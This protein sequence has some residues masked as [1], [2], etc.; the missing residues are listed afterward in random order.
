MSK[1]TPLNNETRNHIRSAVLKHRFEKEAKRLDKVR[2]GTADEFYNQMLTPSQRRIINTAPEGWFREKTGVFFYVMGESHY[3][4]FP[5][6]KPRR[7]P[8][9]FERYSNNAVR[10]SDSEGVGLTVKTYYADKKKMD[11]D[12]DAASAAVG[13]TLRAFRYVEDLVEAWPEVKKFIPKD[14]VKAATTALAIPPKQLNE[15]LGLS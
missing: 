14:A 7:V 9:N 6:D 15:M 11:D 10:A 2:D 3:C 4:A 13:E 8:S 1:K 12:R 5:D